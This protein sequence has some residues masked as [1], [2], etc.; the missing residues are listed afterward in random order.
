MRLAIV[1][2]GMVL[3]AFGAEDSW[4]KVKQLKSGTEVRIFKA[5]D[6]AGII[7]K[8]DEADDERA[9]VVVKNEQKAI[10]KGE[11]ERLEARP[12][13]G[14]G[15]TKSS[16]TKQNDPAAEVGRPKPR[17]SAPVPDLS[18]SGSSLTF[19]GKPAFELVYRR[20]IGKQA[21]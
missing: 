12:L 5:G 16:S 2:V 17:G 8:F 6:K 14:G 9:V 3:A 21:Q 11:I 10:A 19:D 4:T 20:A 1:S 15:M 18:S 7:A 13:K